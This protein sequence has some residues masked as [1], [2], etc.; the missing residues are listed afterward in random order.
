MSIAE[1]SRKS[2]FVER[3]RSNLLKLAETCPPV[4]AA[5]G[6]ANIITIAVY[7]YVASMVAGIVTI[8]PA[9]GILAV[10]AGRFCLYRLDLGLPALESAT[11]HRTGSPYRRT[12]A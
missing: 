12:A 9:L 7:A 5:K 2:G 6:R 4:I 3:V 8:V 10:L 1:G 11:G